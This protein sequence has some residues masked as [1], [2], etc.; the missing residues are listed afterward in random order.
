METVSFTCMRDGT[1]E[2]YAF[3]EELEQQYAAKLP[4]RIMAAMQNLEGSLSGYRGSP[5]AS[6][7]MGDTRL[8]KK[9]R[10]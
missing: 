6:P 5:R 1:T 8:L 3:L 2:E 10:P 9:L 4:D 7:F